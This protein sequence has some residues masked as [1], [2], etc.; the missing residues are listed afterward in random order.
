MNLSG[1]A[2]SHSR[3]S[4]RQLQAAEPTAPGHVTTLLFEE[5]I[6]NGPPAGAGTDS[7]F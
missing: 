3:R 6:P 7:F 4:R 5:H 2:S 1:P